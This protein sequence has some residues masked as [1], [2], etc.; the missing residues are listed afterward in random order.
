MDA[1]PAPSRPALQ[2][3]LG[4]VTLWGLGVGYVVSGEYFGWNLGLPLGGTYGMLAATLVV[5]VMYVTF[6]LSYAELAC[7]LPRAGGAFVYCTRALGPGWGCLAGVV[8]VIEFVFAPP[9]IAMAIGA[10]VSQRFPGAEPRVI[11][12]AAYALFTT[13]NVWGVRQAALFELVVTVLAVAELLLFMGIVAPSFSLEAFQR[14][15]LPNGWSGAVAALPFAI[16]FYLAIEGVANAAEEARNP[17]RDVALGFGAALLTLVLLALGVFFTA[18]GVGGWRAIVYAPGSATPS[19]A[20]L[21]L[22]L[23]LVVDRGSL[24]YTLLLGV[25]LLG[26][27]ASFHGIILA[28]GRA[29]M[30]LGRSGYAPRALG[31]VGARTHTPV[32]ALA[33]NMAAGIAA[34]LSGR[35]GDIIT[36]SC[37]G[38][39]SLYALSMAALF[40]LRRREP[41]L[42]RP[43]RAL[44]YPVF[45]AVAFVLALLSLGALAFYNRTIALVFLALLAGG[46]A[47][48]V[49]FVRGRVD[50]SW[51]R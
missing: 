24:V 29:T 47:Y 43:F 28:A 11:A 1:S 30:E 17:Q 50:A 12:I 40:A 18:V 25:G 37:F 35:T 49:L 31:Y 8:Q 41:A 2:R 20:P 32:V 44:A 34:I 13:L 16:W 46:G 36:L 7:A 26:L 51:T 42:H 19:D 14:D 15:A 39:V 38:A 27:V 4:A 3:T 5:T 21:P 22:A 6:V 45:P 9:A 10:Y 33:V 48:Y 23:A